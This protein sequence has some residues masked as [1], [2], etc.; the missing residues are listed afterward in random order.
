[1]T[2]DLVLVAVAS[3]LWGILACVHMNIL[4]ELFTRSPRWRAYIALFFPLA[5]PLIGAH[6]G[7]V[8][9][10]VLW[11]ILALSCFGLREIFRV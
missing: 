10:S 7:L 3:A 6:A 1:M 2:R 9:R 4:F 11:G 8:A 5:T